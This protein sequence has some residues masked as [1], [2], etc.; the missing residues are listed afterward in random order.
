MKKNT[1]TSLHEVS[2]VSSNTTRYS[3][4]QLVASPLTGVPDCQ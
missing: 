3:K 1:L 2:T 4:S